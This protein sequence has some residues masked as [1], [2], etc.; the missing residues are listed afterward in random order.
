MALVKMYVSWGWVVFFEKENCEKQ[1]KS[2]LY[3][4]TVYVLQLYFTLLE[5]WYNWAN[6]ILDFYK[7]S[8]P[9]LKS[10]A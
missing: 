5:N 9:D 3:I 4:Q 6:Y 8:N 2:T 10:L 1:K 7:N